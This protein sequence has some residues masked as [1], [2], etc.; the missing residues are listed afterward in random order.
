[1]DSELTAPLPWQQAHWDSLIAR[2]RSGQ[3]PHALLLSG[4]RGLGKSLFARALA[5]SLMCETPGEGGIACGQCRACQQFEAGSLPDYKHVHPLEGKS[6]IAIDQCRELSDFMALTSHYGRYRIVILEPAEQMN[7]AAANSLLKT[8]EEPPQGSLL[9]LVTSQADS[10]LPTIRSRCQQLVFQPP[11]HEEASAWL[12]PRLPD[13]QQAE[14]LLSLACDAPLLALEMAE[15]GQLELRQGLLK[16]LE[17][18]TS[19]RVDVSA[20]AA[21]WSDSDAE[22]VI[23]WLQ[24]WFTDMVRLKTE[25]Q[26]PLLNNPDIKVH[27]QQLA[28]AVNWETLYGLLDRLNEMTRRL[29]GSL[30]TQ[31]M[32]EDF[33][34]SWTRGMRLQ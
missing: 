22:Q 18:L 16:D 9:I 27:L 21:R 1:M 3:L 7:V 19:G 29:Q 11:S 32:L 6:V 30:N 28:Q 26:P 34:I 13:P 20:I 14:L 8:L 23:I 2:H 24:T 25:P 10:L 4:N 31:L 12:N 15:G 5:K 33:L 17:Q